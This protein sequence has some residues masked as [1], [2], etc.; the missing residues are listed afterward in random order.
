MKELFLLHY[1]D[2]SPQAPKRRLWFAL[3]A[4]T[5]TEVTTPGASRLSEISLQS[6]HLLSRKLYLT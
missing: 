6:S 2:M 1:R 4:I 3:V 5:C